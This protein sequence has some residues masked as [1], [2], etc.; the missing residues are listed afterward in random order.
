MIFLI[1]NLILFVVTLAIAA[2]EAV[3]GKKPSKVT[4]ALVSL[5]VALTASQASWYLFFKEEK[6]N[7]EL[8]SKLKIGTSFIGDNNTVY[9]IDSLSSDSTYVFTGNK[10]FEIEKFKSEKFKIIK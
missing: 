3:S 1:F 5:T 10:A 6:Q 2:G 7:E 4:I 9:R 8:Y